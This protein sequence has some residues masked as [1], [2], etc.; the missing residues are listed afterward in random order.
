MSI[1]LETAKKLKAAGFPQD[2][3]RG[4][5]PDGH[6]YYVTANDTN[7]E[8]SAP[9]T[10]EFLAQ[11]PKT[12]SLEQSLELISITRHLEGD[13][14]SESW[15]VGYTHSNYLTENESLPEALAEMWILLKE[16]G[17]IK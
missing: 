6:W 16:K 3:I 4:Y 5:F 2:T 9:D 10:D 17:I 14:F 7:M 1:T 13:G 12:I 11:L 15:E 8:C